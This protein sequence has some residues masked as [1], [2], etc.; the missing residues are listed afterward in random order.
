MEN[1]Y[2]CLIVDD[3]KAS[4]V[5]LA[6]YI[7]YINTLELVGEKYNIIEAVN[8][9][10]DQPVDLIFLDINMPHFTGFDLFKMLS[11]PPAVII[12]TA[13]TEYALAGYEVGVIDYL[14]K[15]IEFHRFSKAVDKY[16]L[17]RVKSTG[18]QA[19]APAQPETIAVKVNS[20]II[21][22]KLDDITYIK[23]MGNYVKLN[24]G[25][26]SYMCTTSTVD[27]EKK[28]PA[29]RFVRIH[30]SFIVSTKKIE[31]IADGNVYI[32]GT[33]LPVG[34]TYLRKLENMFKKQ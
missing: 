7:G 21:N 24:T 8:F 29:E 4:H 5:V 33:E 17:T 30:K 11:K 32:D 10:H 34:I 23:S 16:L 26:K 22:I 3:E 27:L 6:N 9:L 13:Y 25:K 2:K 28:L 20:D 1:R 15:P 19:A 12:T 18:E 14:L 31:R